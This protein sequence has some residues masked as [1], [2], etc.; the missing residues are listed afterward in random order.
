MVERAQRRL[1]SLDCSRTR[2]KTH[3]S[4]AECAQRRLASL[5]C[6]Q[7]VRTACQIDRASAQRRLASLDCSQSTRSRRTCRKHVLN[8]VWRH[9]IVHNR[10]PG[11][12]GLYRTCSTPFGVIGLFTSGKDTRVVSNRLV[13]NAVW[14]HWIVHASEHIS[15]FSLYSV[16]NAVWRH[17]IVH[18]RLAMQQQHG[19]WCSTPFG[20]IGLFTWSLHP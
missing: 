15:D 9:W 12:M 16:L 4:P 19:I 13:L 17:W 2:H 14:R 6:S 10:R 3:R 11:S 5:D 8:A 1:A 18:R 7:I 20:V